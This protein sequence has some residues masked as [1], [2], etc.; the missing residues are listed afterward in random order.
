MEKYGTKKVK[1]ILQLQYDK[2]V[3]DT[4]H[5]LPAAGRGMKKNNRLPSG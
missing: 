2:S 5:T 3:H 1:I 4:I